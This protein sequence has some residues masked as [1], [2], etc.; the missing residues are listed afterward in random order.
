[1]FRAALQISWKAVL[2]YRRSPRWSVRKIVMFG[3]PDSAPAALLK[4]WHLQCWAAGWVRQMLALAQEANRSEGRK[5]QIQRHIQRQE[6]G[7][8]KGKFKGKD[9]AKN[10]Y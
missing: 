2:R 10:Y 7:K 8:F 6:Q 3:S 1:M 5:K 4:E 9:H